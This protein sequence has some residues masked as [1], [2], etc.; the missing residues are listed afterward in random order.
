[1]TDTTGIEWT[2]YI[3]YQRSGSFRPWPNCARGYY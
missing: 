2:A 3:I 1:M